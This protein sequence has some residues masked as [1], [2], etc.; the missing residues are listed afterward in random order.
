ML[1]IVYKPVMT[2]STQMIT[3]LRLEDVRGGP[4]HY[5]AD[6]GRRS[7]DLDHRY[8]WRCRRRCLYLQQ[9]MACFKLKSED[10]TGSSPIAAPDIKYWNLRFP[11]ISCFCSTQAHGPQTVYP[12][13]GGWQTIYSN[14]KLILI[15]SPVLISGYILA[16]ILICLVGRSILKVPNQSMKSLSKL[17]W[18]RMPDQARKSRK[19]NKPTASRHFAEE[20]EYM[21]CCFFSQIMPQPPKKSQPSFLRSG[22]G[23]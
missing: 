4:N 9:Q 10:C 21:R 15:V 1:K 23:A 19:L 22:D 5:R 3:I 18:S 12:T 13:V 8:M 14:T 2:L 17:L 7:I 11:A 6:P 20:N 16:Q